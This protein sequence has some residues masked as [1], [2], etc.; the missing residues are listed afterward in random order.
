MAP[1]PAGLGDLPP[2]FWFRKGPL[3]GPLGPFQI[4]GGGQLMD[5]SGPEEN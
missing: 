3:K 2:T 1:R 5:H 4:G